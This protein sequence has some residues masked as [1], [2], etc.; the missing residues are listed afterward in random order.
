MQELG[1]G[2]ECGVALEPL[3]LALLHPNLA[4]EAGPS[5]TRIL[6]KSR[7]AR[8]LIV[9]SENVLNTIAA[10]LCSSQRMNKLLYHCLPR[11]AS[12]LE[13]LQAYMG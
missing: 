7:Q 12:C 6:G 2:L 11:Y 4:G 8:F 13:N 3:G 9:W 1:A 5:F 10:L